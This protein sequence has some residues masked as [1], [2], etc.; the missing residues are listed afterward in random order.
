MMEAMSVG[1]PTVC[2]DWTGMGVIVNDQSGI[3]VEVSDYDQV[4]KDFAEGIVKLA[5]N[6]ELRKQ[7]GLNAK[8]AMQ[9]N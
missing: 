3:K 1:L 9:A 2:L 6:S 8:K 4:N 5:N 7:L